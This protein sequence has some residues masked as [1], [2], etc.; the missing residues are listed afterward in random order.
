[1][2][3]VA[4]RGQRPGIGLHEEGCGGGADLGRR[5][6][7]PHLETGGGG[8]WPNQLHSSDQGRLESLPLYDEKKLSVLSPAQENIYSRASEMN[9]LKTE[10]N[11]LL[12]CSQMVHLNNVGPCTY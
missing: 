6:A 9:I 1:M 8:R 12:K 2:E 4:T 11:G 10:D 7:W 5:V 3:G